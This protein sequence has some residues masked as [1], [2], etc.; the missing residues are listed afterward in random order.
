MRVWNA[1]PNRLPWR[2]RIGRYATRA[3]ATAI[4]NRLKR[5][6]VDAFVVEAEAR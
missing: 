3:E 1:T 2:V 6:G 4:V 5:D